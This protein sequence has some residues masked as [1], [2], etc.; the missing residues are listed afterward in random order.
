VGAQRPHGV[1]S[2]RRLGE[3]AES[4]KTGSAGDVQPHSSFS[5]SLW[6]GGRSKFKGSS[7]QSQSEACSKGSKRSR[8]F[9]GFR[10]PKDVRSFVDSLLPN[11]NED[12]RVHDNSLHVSSEGLF[13]IGN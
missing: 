9:T 2:P 6:P 10:G 13:D 4:G 1:N 5:Q 7:V 11:E 12:P 3:E 8:S